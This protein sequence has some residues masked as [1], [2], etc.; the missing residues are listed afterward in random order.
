MT[1]FLWDLWY[2]FSCHVSDTITYGYT[3]ACR[4]HFTSSGCQILLN[5]EKLFPR[6][7]KLNFNESFWSLSYF[8]RWNVLQ[9][10]TIGWILRRF[11]S[12]DDQDT[13]STITWTEGFYISSQ[14][15]ECWEFH[16]TKLWWGKYTEIAFTVKFT[17]LITTR[18]K[19]NK[20]NTRWLLL[21]LKF[22]D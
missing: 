7:G 16:R 18:A 5:I 15:S 12:W 10:P 22:M 13:S 20:S 21:I 14:C 4:S 8:W 6:S 1:D 11:H 2:G 3:R 9:C 17:G 19:K